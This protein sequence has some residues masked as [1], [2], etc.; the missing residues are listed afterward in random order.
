MILK[1]PAVVATLNSSPFS[2]T[3]AIQFQDLCC[4]ADLSVELQ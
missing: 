2:F 3:F 1:T 4:E